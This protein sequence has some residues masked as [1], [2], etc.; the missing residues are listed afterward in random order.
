M[1]I[2]SC[3]RNCNLERIHYVID[4]NLPPAVR[5]KSSGV[6]APLSAGGD[7]NTDSGGGE[8]LQLQN[9]IEEL[10]TRVHESEVRYAE[11]E[12]ERDRYVNQLG[13]IEALCHSV[14]E[15]DQSPMI[16]DILTVLYR[17]YAGSEAS[18]EDQVDDLVS[19]VDDLE[20]STED[21][22]EELDDLPAK[23]LYDSSEEY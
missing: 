10:K 4:P 5:S 14:G 17:S 16:K 2:L 9:R 22:V 6:A 13:E 15:E 23:V 19:A 3:N 18:T 12:Q 7:N 11:V 21:Q 8:D 1:K 20:V